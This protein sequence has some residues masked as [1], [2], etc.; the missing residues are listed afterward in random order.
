M[1]TPLALRPTIPTGR[2]PEVVEFVPPL[3]V[4]LWEKVY[5]VI[6]LALSLFGNVPGTTGVGR[7]SPVI[8]SMSVTEL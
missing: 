1:A 2:D 6:V 8:V 5:D 4:K 3:K 7:P